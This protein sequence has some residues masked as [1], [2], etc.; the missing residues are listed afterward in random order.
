MRS[1]EIDENSNNLKENDEEDNETIYIQLNLTLRVIKLVNEHS[2][3]NLFSGSATVL[4]FR[5]SSFPILI[6][7]HDWVL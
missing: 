7:Y 2:F 3:Q 4:I 5:F 6:Y 1:F